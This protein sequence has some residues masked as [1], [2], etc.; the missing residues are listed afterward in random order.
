MVRLSISSV[1]R[2]WRGLNRGTPGIAVINRMSIST[3]GRLGTACGPNVLAFSKL[4]RHWHR[5]P[6]Q[7]R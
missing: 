5:I 1:D 7:M 6:L 4:A 3:D 2:V